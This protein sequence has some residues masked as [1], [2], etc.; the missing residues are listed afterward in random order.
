MVFGLIW[1]V[2]P[3]LPVAAANLAQD[4]VTGNDTEQI[5]APDAP[6]AISVTVFRDYDAD[7]VKDTLEPGVSGVT[8]TAYRPSASG[9]A[10]PV[11][12]TGGTN[13]VYSLATGSG[14]YRIEVTGLP[15]YLFS[16]A[17]GATTTAFIANG[18]SVAIGL[19]N[20]G[21]YAPS[22]TL[23]VAI[24]RHQAAYRSDVDSQW[25]ISRFVENAGSTSTVRESYDLPEDTE[26]ALQGEIGTTWGVAHDSINDRLLAGSMVKRFGRLKGNPTTIYS[27]PL[28]GA[29][30]PTAWV[31]LDAA[32][33]NPHGAS[34]NWYQDHAVIPFV[35]KEGLGDVDIAEDGSMVYTIDLG[36]REF[37]RIPVNANGSAGTPVKVALLPALGTPSGCSANGDLRPFGL[38]VNDGKVYLG[39]VCSA[40]STVTAGSLP[41]SLITYPK[42]GDRTKLYAYIYEWN[43]A[44]GFTQRLNFPLNYERGCVAAADTLTTN[45]TTWGNAGW[46]AWAPVYP[47]SQLGGWQGHHYPQPLIS[48]IEFVNGDMI[49]GMA[50]RFSFMDGFNAVE[51]TGFTSVV[52]NSAGD[53]LRAC[54]TGP[55]TW[56]MEK[57][58]SGN[59]ACDTAGLGYGVGNTETIDE[60]FHDDDFAH[61]TSNTLNPKIFSEVSL[62][63]VL[64]IPGRDYVATSA[65]NASRP[66]SLAWYEEGVHFYNL[67]SGNWIRGYRLWN[68]TSPQ[69]LG[70]GSGLGD[71]EAL[72]DPAPLEIG[73]RLWCDTG[74]VNG[75]GAYNGVQDPGE[76][77]I[78]N[79]TV[80]LQCD[81]NGSP[82]SFEATANATT[83]A[84][85]LY[86]FKDNTGNITGANGWPAATWD[87][88]VRIIPRTAACRLVVN[89]TQAAI[90]SSCG[91]SALALSNN[92][93]TDAGADLRDSDGIAGVGGAGYSGV[94]FT[95]GKSGENDHSLDFGFTNKVGSIGNYVWVDENSD[96]YQD[97][98]EPGLPNVRVNLY[99]S[100]GTVV[101]TTVT[102]AHGGYLF[103]NLSPGAYFVRV[104]ST[105]LPAGMTQTTIYTNANAD[106][107]NQNQSSGFGYAATIGGSSPWENLTADFGYN[108]NPT[109]DVNS[110]TNTA[111]IGDRVWVDTDSD[112]K[113]DPEEVG[114]SGVTVTLKSAGADGL[115]GTADD[116][117]VATTTTNATGNYL[118][119][120]LAPGA[121]VVTVTP[122]AGYTQTGDPDHYAVTNTTAAMNDN[123]TTIPVVLGPG[124]VFLL[125]DFGYVAPAAQNNSVGNKVWFDADADGVGPSGA[126]GGGDTTEWG[127]PG[128]TVALIRDT[129]GNGTWDAGEPIVATDT[130]DA[131][132]VYGFSGLPDGNY[133]VWVNDT[134]NVLGEM[135]QT[136]DS[137]GIATPNLSSVA[138]DPTGASATAVSNQNQ[139]F[140]YTAL[141]QTTTAG[142]NGL[143]GDT[144]WFDVDN[145]GGATQQAGEPGIEGVVIELLNSGGTVIATTTTDENGHYAFG[146][147][148][149]SAGGVSYTVRVAASNFAANGVLE[150]MA[151]SYAAGGTVGSHLS[152]TVTLT[153]AAPVNLAQ[154]FSYAATTSPASLGNLVWLDS[155]ADGTFTAT[156]GQNT[157]DPNTGSD[158]D[159]PAIGGVTIDLY[160]DLNANGRVDAGEPKLSSTTTV[161]TINAATYGTNGT[162]LFTDL[163]GDSY[164]VN[165]TDVNGVLAG[166]WMSRG[167]ANTD[168]NSQIDPYAVTVAAGA[169][170]LTADFGYYVEPA[171]VGNFV[172]FDVNGDGIQQ[173][174]EPGM[175]NVT[176]TMVVSYAN[177]TSATLK[178]LTGDNPATTAVETG[179]YSFGNLLLDEDYRIGSTSTTA[180]ATT[181]AHVISVTDPSGFVRTRVGGADGNISTV[182]LTDSNDHSST[183][184]VPTQGLS[185][186]VQQTASIEPLI[187]GYDFGYLVLDYGDLPN[188]YG[189]LLASNGAR[190]AISNALYLGACVDADLDG[191][192]LATA[193]G[194]DNT[195]ST[196]TLN[197]SAYPVN[198]PTTTCADDENGVAMTYN[199]GNSIWREGSVASLLG[200]ALRITIGS[201]TGASGVPQL[202]MDFGSGTLTAVTL[203]TITGTAISTPLAAGEYTVYFD[204]PA[205]AC[206]ATLITNLEARV[207]LSSAGGLTSTGLASNGEVE[208]YIF[209]CGATAPYAVT[210]ANFAAESTATG[211]QVTWETVSEQDN[212]GFIVTRSSSA[213]GERV[214]VTQVASLAAGSNQGASYT[215]TDSE[216]TLGQTWW[217]W[218]EDVAL[219]GTVTLH[220][221]VSV[222]HQ[223]PSA[224][225]LGLL[226]A[227]D[228]STTLPLALVLVV[229]AALLLT[230][231][232]WRLQQ[233]R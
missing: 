38:G 205:G 161:A 176:V 88:A 55:D 86:L 40:E 173:A 76:A 5:A 34:P 73:N 178:T 48:D 231:L 190:H 69:T 21:Q 79:A 224:V 23:E 207:R 152:S 194:D 3:G 180:G 121:Y 203:R 2:L 4:Q 117:T 36:T 87:S 195:A 119:D 31:T 179:W 219:D 103:T 210:L 106:F 181:P 213:D 188:S 1:A 124:D 163:P 143:I 191:Q 113:Q 122:P 16:G 186:T 66:V 94:T 185:N 228:N 134:D 172:W 156:T 47:I 84:N 225:T 39:V 46:L 126:P 58:I 146:G 8:V 211:V 90:L 75:V 151:E 150:G 93:G 62:G 155:N 137:N 81:T 54:S 165:V 61:D 132:G 10:S 63:G 131:N 212:A 138:L 14:T 114:I 230:L 133:L 105:T 217:Y 111:T 169:T 129:N 233:A 127:I 170:V 118:F 41:T 24:A 91:G 12:A 44:S 70:K 216:A 218:L 147:L 25:A 182:P 18:A 92:G 98:G 67:A 200:G 89:S 37:V 83:D 226:Q 107:G 142:S 158:D 78:A 51:P 232:G 154:D 85:G 197:G 201:S 22:T 100:A 32:R 110:N 80:T 144:V 108:Y 177:G 33:T 167:T 149:T 112:G 99:N 115:F 11:V 30:A 160:R 204:I 192:P 141:G 35:G 214:Q 50:D 222:L 196:Q 184:A 130:T 42:P 153:T 174:T 175:N 65:F 209:Q 140:G 43:G 71:M 215:I 199:A 128:V 64:A 206:P 17:Q 45:C 68:S 120:G 27:V 116:V 77:V 53:T 193:A 57:L 198:L 104:D 223:A 136:Y 102:D 168:N 56:V 109:P 6:D 159:E 221:P 97:A 208:D 60:Y 202:F 183:V 9:Y 157:G 227:G 19:A 29:A 52:V 189:T 59:T 101:A 20:P 171:A 72:V 15:A 148:P 166:Y 123:K 49:L 162:Y 164:V 139:D 96:G 125:V 229:G 28:S 145:S 74:N 95:T 7:G 82:A 135:R 187:A 26:G 220:G 13:G